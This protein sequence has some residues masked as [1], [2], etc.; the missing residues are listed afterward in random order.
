M[1]IVIV[2]ALISLPYTAIPTYI[3]YTYEGNMNKFYIF[4]WKS[5]NTEDKKINAKIRVNDKK[6]KEKKSEKRRKNDL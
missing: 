4:L 5:G 1:D 2:G 6:K 3:I